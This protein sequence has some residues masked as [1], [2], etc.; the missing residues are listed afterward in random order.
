MSRGPRRLSRNSGPVNGREPMCG[1]RIIP[2]MRILTQV[3]QADLAQVPAAA[4]AAEA[5]GYDGLST[6]ENRNDPFLALGVAAVNT[7]RVSLQT[8]IAIAFS[9]SPMAVAN[10]SWDLQNASRG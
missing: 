7:A 3:P 9:R 2:T 10:A 1:D 5:A 6:S 4:G 8:S